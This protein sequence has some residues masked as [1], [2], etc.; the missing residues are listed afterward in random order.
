MNITLFSTTQYEY[1]D[2]VEETLTDAGYEVQR[3]SEKPSPDQLAKLLKLIK[4]PQLSIG[5]VAYYG[6][7]IPQEI[8]DLFPKGILNIHPSLLPKYRGPSPVASAILNGDETTGVTIFRIDEEMDHGPILAQ[9]QLPV[10]SNDTRDTLLTRLFSAGAELLTG[11]LPDYLSGQLTPTPQNHAQATYTKMITKE[12]GRIDWNASDVEIE[13]QIR[14]LTPWPGTWAKIN[15]KRVLVNRA[16]LN[17]DGELII[18]E[19]Q[20]AGKTT[21]KGSWGKEQFLAY[22]R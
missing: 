9:E 6:A 10:Y 12:D 22:L 14:A 17:T 7:I 4:L 3:I 1:G 11:I 15:G 18:D 13:R 8:I 20:V 2:I 19:F 21:V 16:H 5:V